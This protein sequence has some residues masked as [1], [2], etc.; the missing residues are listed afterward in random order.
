MK[1]KERKTFTL[2]ANRINTE[3]PLPIIIDD[4][5]SIDKAT[6]IEI[7]LIKHKIDD[8]VNSNLAIGSSNPFEMV[9]IEEEGKRR[10]EN[11][12]NRS[13]IAEKNNWQYWVVRHN[14]RRRL[15]QPYETLYSLINSE[16]KPIMDFYSDYYETEEG[17]KISGDK[18]WNAFAFN[19]I[20]EMGHTRKETYINNEDI[21][22]LQKLLKSY[23]KI[24]FEN[25]EFEFIKRSIHNYRILMSMKIYQDLRVIGKFAIIESL[26]TS[27]NSIQLNSINF[28]LQNKIPL[29]NNRLVEKINFR[30]NLDNLPDTFTDH[31]IIEK[32]YNYRSCIAHGNKPDFKEN[33][34][35][36]KNSVYADDIVDEICR[37]IMAHAITEPELINDLRK[38]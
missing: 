13:K 11:P 23:E 20:Y 7:N 36:L 5:N 15:K 2:L 18:G 28:Q 21:I 38:C 1:F 35:H 10:K 6:D 16:L 14:N 3:L 29:I 27:R 22:Y 34:Q 19:Q 33:L 4:E 17:I 8:I 30:N 31:K 37:K 26:L 12:P 25:D 24:D 32:L 9:S